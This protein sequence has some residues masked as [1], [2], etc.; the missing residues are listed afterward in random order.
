MLEN[1]PR[2][3]PITIALNARGGRRIECRPQ[4]LDHYPQK[5]GFP[6][7]MMVFAQRGRVAKSPNPE[8]IFHIGLNLNYSYSTSGLQKNNDWDAGHASLHRLC[9]CGHLL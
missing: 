2:P 8:T 3:E 6:T 5:K 1:A 9:G 4:I 7:G